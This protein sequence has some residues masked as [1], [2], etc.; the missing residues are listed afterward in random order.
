MTGATLA[1]YIDAVSTATRAS[2]M[3]SSEAMP[4]LLHFLE[5][6]FPRCRPHS[7]PCP[8]FREQECPWF[9]EKEGR[10]QRGP[11]TVE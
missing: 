8:W 4:S 11:E 5:V 6:A 1:H 10:R 7:S 2:E 3:L 9:R